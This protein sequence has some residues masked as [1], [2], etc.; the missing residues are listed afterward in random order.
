MA[1]RTMKDTKHS[2]PTDVSGDDAS[3]ALALHLQEEE[4]VQARARNVQMKEKKK[5]N[6]R[7]RRLPPQGNVWARGRAKTTAVVSIGEQI[8]KAAAER[9]WKKELENY[10]NGGQR[11]KSRSRS[12]GRKVP[13]HALAKGGGNF[14]LQYNIWKQQEDNIERFKAPNISSLLQLDGLKN[15]FP[16]VSHSIVEEAF[17][18]AGRNYEV[19]LLWLCHNYPNA[20]AKKKLHALQGRQ[21][22]PLVEFNKETAAEEEE[23]VKANA[24]ES[25]HAAELRNFILSHLGASTITSRENPQKVYNNYRSKIHDLRKQRDK[26]LKK[27]AGS[28]GHK[29]QGTC[30]LAVVVDEV[31]LI[32]TKIRRAQLE[33]IKGIYLFTNR[34]RDNSRS[35]DLHGLHVT[36]SIKVLR[37]LL[38]IAGKG[39]YRVI[40]GKDNT[41]VA[42]RALGQRWSDSLMD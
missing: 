23:E 17:M 5:K 3:L 38:T 33:A 14:I 13:L 8:D 20:K 32:R 11:R 30:A 25:S 21:S 18:D 40:T 29:Q 1:M 41:A 19:A 2:P 22:V 12:R 28:A 15:L 34:G 35:V 24:D 16:K 26:I 36:E 42:R 7:R 4:N 9:L 10:A 31:R 37:I 39:E 27:A 6:T